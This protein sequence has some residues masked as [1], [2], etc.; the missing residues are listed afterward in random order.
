M[1]LKK[2]ILENFRGFRVRQEIDFS[3]EDGALNLIIA[4]N[5]VG[6]T[7]I[8]NAVLWCLYDKL[9]SSS[10]N[11]HLI[12]N[13]DADENE[14]C[15]VE[16]HLTPIEGPEEDE[17][18]I[19][20]RRVLHKKGEPSIA[21][22]YEVCS[23]TE[24]ETDTHFGQMVNSFLPETL[25]GYYFFDG[26]GVHEIVENETLLKQAILNIQ[27]LNIASRSLRDLEKFTNSRRSLLT[28]DEKASKELAGFADKI[29][30]LEK[31]Y[32]E[33]ESKLQ[34]LAKKDIEKS[35]EIAKLRAENRSLG[36]EEIK[37][38][39]KLQEKV[40]KVIPKAKTRIKFFE[41]ERAQ[42]I[43]KY[44][45]PIM[46]YNH[47]TNSNN[48]I[49]KTS[50]TTGI[51]SHYHEIFI[52]NLLEA[53]ICICGESFKNHKKD[54]SHKKMYEKI[55]ALK[56][57]A[58][59]DEINAPI[60]DINSLKGHILKTIP[61]FNGEYEKNQTELSNWRNDLDEAIKEK[62]ELDSALGGSDLD[63][64]AQNQ[65]TISEIETDRYKIKNNQISLEGQQ[66]KLA[67]E[68]KENRKL[69]DKAPKNTFLE[70]QR[71]E[72]NFLEETYTFYE[73][74][75]ESTRI[76]GRKRIDAEMN[77]LLREYARGNDVFTFRG[78]SYDM[79]MLKDDHE[80][81]DPENI[82]DADIRVLSRGGA[83]VKRNL[84]FAI[85]LSKI[86]ESDDGDDD[87]DYRIKGK[88]V[89]YLVDA[90]F[91]NLDST[92]T[93]VLFKL[94]ADHA[95]QGIMLISSGAYN[96][97][98]EEILKEK[99][100]KNKLKK[101]YIL[102]R[103]YKGKEDSKKGIGTTPIEINGKSYDTSFYEE[104]IET[105]FVEDWSSK[106]GIKT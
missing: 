29:E 72:M 101:F 46:S 13:Q 17:K 16:I 3:I 6:K 27:G 93:S 57:K 31:K 23:V 69:R 80:E 49:A 92:N 85:A 15:L 52:D 56:E 58:Q 91:S 105:T 68:L 76:K 89:P 26:E 65:K 18:Y 36:D 51:P 95:F 1:K 40:D 83:A 88:K 82:D 9:T 78:D 64:I 25:A 70:N 100:Y 96:N 42:L 7:S 79:V 10:D 39:V 55:L 71:K 84:F 81:V 77:R 106:V 50:S 48:W 22:A 60:S 97:G 5:E 45:I 59:T 14:K 67:D 28:K 35:K 66:N 98:I 24:K 43:Q 11:E 62:S 34:D 75:I 74:L 63:K 99:K 61:K 53:E 44:G 21:R 90:P 12:K 32:E 4:E 2:I 73:N 104:K 54:K 103:S 87:F 37:N 20:L 86:S 94:L 30:R 38:K 47:I 33:N 8:L 19:A 41:K 102:K